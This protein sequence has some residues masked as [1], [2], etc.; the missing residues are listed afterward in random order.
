[1]KTIAAILSI[2]LLSGCAMM[3][4][5]EDRQS[6]IAG[7]ENACIIYLA[8]TQNLMW[9]SAILTHNLSATAAYYN[10]PEYNRYGIDAP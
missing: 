3:D 7:N 2:L 6:C 8:E 5:H 4:A 10:A 1:M 9:A